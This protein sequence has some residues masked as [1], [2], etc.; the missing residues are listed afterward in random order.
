MLPAY[1]RSYN[2]AACN[3]VCIC[4]DLSHGF[5]V[6][7][8][9][10]FVCVQGLL[11]PLHWA[12]RQHPES[13]R[14]SSPYEYATLVTLP[15]LVCKQ[16]HTW[17]LVLHG[18]MAPGPCH[19]RW[20]RRTVLPA[21]FLA[22]IRAD[23]VP[24]CRY[25]L[26]FAPRNRLPP[27]ATGHQRC[28][29]CRCYRRQKVC[30]DVRRDPQHVNDEVGSGSSHTACAAHHEHGWAMTVPHH[31]HTHTT[32]VHTH[33]PYTRTAGVCGSYE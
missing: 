1:P 9:Q 7:S 29:H 25:F 33:T 4:W 14:V 30:Y 17:L 18:L 2:P 27:A 32:H 31:T 26:R 24:P 20:C 12:Q 21:H 3:N 11:V 13:R 10:V 5:C 23:C 15:S 28:H 6:G 16:E 22:P 19:F 8:W